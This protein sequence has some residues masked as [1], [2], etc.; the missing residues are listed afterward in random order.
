MAICIKKLALKRLVLLT[1][2]V[3]TMVLT[4]SSFHNPFY[5]SV[6]MSESTKLS[7]PSDGDN[8]TH[9]DNGKNEM[10]Q[11]KWDVLKESICRNMVPNANIWS[12]L[13]E[14]ARVELDFAKERIPTNPLDANFT[15][16]FFTFSSGGVGY[17][18]SDKIHHMVYLRVWKAGNDQIRKNLMTTLSEQDGSKTWERKGRLLEAYDTGWPGLW[19]PIPKIQLN[20]TC[21]VTALRDPIS[22]FISGYNELEYRVAAHHPGHQWTTRQNPHPNN[23]ARFENGTEIRFEQFVTDLVG[24]AASSSNIFPSMPH[25]NIYHVFSMT[26]ILWELKRLRDTLGVMVDAPHLTDYLPTVDNLNTEFPKFLSR[27]CNGIPPAADKPW[28]TTLGDHESREDEFGF[29]NAAKRVWKNQDKISRALCA[30][31]TL[32]YACFDKLPIPDLC[33]SLYISDRFHNELIKAAT[34]KGAR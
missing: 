25:W 8:I 16:Q 3:F 2:A 32:D 29:Y 23:F 14:L 7:Q 24:G 27:S 21:I 15:K 11:Q 22:H 20:Q 6:S 4:Y 12:L 1:I 17:T 26:G 10:K 28:N 19:S 5:L 13:F 9:I 18:S 30:I 31:H 33:Q 34:G